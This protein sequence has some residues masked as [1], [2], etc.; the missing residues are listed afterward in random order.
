[1]DSDYLYEVGFIQRIGIMRLKW[2]GQ[3]SFLVTASNGTSIITDPYTPETAG[4]TVVEDSPDIV[5][6]S[7]GNDSFHCRADLIPGNPVVINALELA[8]SSGQRVE[9]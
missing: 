7:S 5:V 4:Y 2:Y 3:A 6:M 9:K 8:D 1:M